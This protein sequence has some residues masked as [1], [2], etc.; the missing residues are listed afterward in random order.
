MRL[1]ILKI[2]IQN[3]LTDMKF[4]KHTNVLKMCIMFYLISTGQNTKFQAWH[5]S[6]TVFTFE[7]CLFVDAGHTKSPAA[8]SQQM[9]LW[10]WLELSWLLG[11]SVYLCPCGLSQLLPPRFLSMPSTPPFSTGPKLVRHWQMPWRLSR[12]ASSTHTLPTGQVRDEI[13]LC[14]ISTL[15]INKVVKRRSL[16]NW[17]LLTLFLFFRIHA[18]WQWCEA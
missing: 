16:W 2:W 7:P 9:V 12:A 4:I 10:D 17:A 13:P 6:F 8:R 15:V 1:T 5:F 11:L 18:D 14:I 3:W